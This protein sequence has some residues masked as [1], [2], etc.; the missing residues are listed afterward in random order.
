MKGVQDQEYEYK[1]IGLRFLASFIPA[2]I[3]FRVLIMGDPMH[4]GKGG[5]I[6]PR[7]FAILFTSIFFGF[8]FKSFWADVTLSDLK[9]FYFDIRHPGHVQTLDGLLDK[10]KKSD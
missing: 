1:G 4:L 6:A 10:D 8:W 9:E 2:F 5:P 3:L 7:W